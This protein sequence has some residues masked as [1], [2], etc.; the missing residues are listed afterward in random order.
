MWQTILSS[1]ADRHSFVLKWIKGQDGF[2]RPE[3]NNQLQLPCVV[4][5]SLPWQ[6]ISV[7]M[8]QNNFNTISDYLACVM[9]APTYTVSLDNFL[10]VLSLYISWEIKGCN[11]ICNTKTYL[12]DL[13]FD[14]GIKGL[15]K[16]YL[17]LKMIMICR[18][19]C[20]AGQVELS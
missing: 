20:P 2:Y 3:A 19:H 10:S 12:K 17:G 13:R 9:T 11:C 1:T 4:L 8:I 18:D 6:H 7:F 14:T 16:D 15:L 5:K